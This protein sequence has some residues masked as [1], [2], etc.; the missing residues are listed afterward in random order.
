MS[1]FSC[2]WFEEASALQTVA[3]TL[4]ALGSVFRLLR[5]DGLLIELW[6]W[7]KVV[8]QNSYRMNLAILTTLLR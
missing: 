8:F 4:Q 7:G 3:A 1:L 6:T 5:L 2:I